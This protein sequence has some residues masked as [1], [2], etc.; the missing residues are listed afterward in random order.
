MSSG[1]KR[2]RQLALRR[3]R[4]KRRLSETAEEREVQLKKRRVSDEPRKRL[5]ENEHVYS[6]QIERDHLKRNEETPDQIQ[7]RL[8]SQRACD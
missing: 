1:E 7:E 5:N 4:E 3:E 6:A 8:Q 2:E